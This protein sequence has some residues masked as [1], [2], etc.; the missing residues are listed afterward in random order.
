M[1]TPESQPEKHT[2]DT[3]VFNGFIYTVEQDQPNVE[4]AAIRDGKIM[5][6]GT[7]EEF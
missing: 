4:A 1:P 2:A 7:S 5:A 3:I 6:L